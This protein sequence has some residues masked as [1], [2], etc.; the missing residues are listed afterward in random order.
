[1][2]DGDK[3]IF[4]YADPESQT[5]E[6]TGPALDPYAQGDLRREP[7]GPSLSTRPF[8]APRTTRSDG[9]FATGWHREGVL[10]GPQFL[11][12]MNAIGHSFFLWLRRVACPG[13]D[14]FLTAV[15]AS[16][17]FK[18]HTKG[19][20]RYEGMNTT[21]FEVKDRFMVDRAGQIDKWLA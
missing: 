13:M 21:G 10:H 17:G 12:G 6:R 8:T 18:N 2:D 5:R 11:G 15:R 7:S 4:D 19:F 1:M 9:L 14:L 20:Q 16:A 3:P